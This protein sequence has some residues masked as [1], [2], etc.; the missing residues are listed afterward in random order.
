M[1]T[2]AIH[3]TELLLQKI[4]LNPEQ[5]GPSF[6]VTNTSSTYSTGTQRLHSLLAKFNPPIS[7]SLVQETIDAF[8]CDG[9]GLVADGVDEESKALRKAA[10]GAVAASIYGRILDTMLQQAT[11]ADAEASW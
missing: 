1:S 5:S 3:Q 4:L 8:K 7:A 11:E 9:H 2:F 10:I 6:L